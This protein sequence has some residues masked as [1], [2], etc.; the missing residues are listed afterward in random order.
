ML[1]VFQTVMYQNA[2]YYDQQYI[3]LNFNPGIN[4][5]PI[6]FSGPAE[7]RVNNS[8]QVSQK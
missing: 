1:S 4:G 7:F 6:C 2:V 5:I 3:E 8:Y